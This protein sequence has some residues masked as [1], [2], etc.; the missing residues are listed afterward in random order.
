MSMTLAVADPERSVVIRRFSVCGACVQ[1]R[2]ELDL[3]SAPLLRAA[4]SA[5]VAEGRRHIV[6]DF[7]RATFL[8]C[9]CLGSILAGMAPL[10]SDCDASLVLA[11]ATGCV[12]RLLT[13]LEFNQVCSLAR[14]VRAAKHLALDPARRDCEGWRATESNAAALIAAVS[15]IE[16][17][18]GDDELSP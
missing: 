11:C 18:G 1:A 5:A 9:A 3:E 8:D 17:D 2:G 7:S 4:I 12:E 10:R 13:L 15:F 14:S 16:T 6:I